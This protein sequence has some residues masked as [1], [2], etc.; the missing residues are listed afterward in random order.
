MF[1]NISVPILSTSWQSSDPEG[2]NGESVNS[3]V[4]KIKTNSKDVKDEINGSEVV[5][6]CNPLCGN[7]DEGIDN[8]KEASHKVN[9]IQLNDKNTKIYKHLKKYP[10]VNSW[11]KIFHWTPLP[12]I[13]HPALIRVLFSNTLNPYTTAIDSYLDAHLTSLDEFFPIVNTLRMRD[14]RNVILDDP[15]KNA[16]SK[17]SNT[18]LNVIDLTEKMI[19]EPTRTCVQQVR[20]LRNEYIPF[21]GNQPIIRSQIHRIFRKLNYI[22]FKNI[23]MSFLYYN[24]NKTHIENSVGT[25]I[26]INYITLA[27]NSG[28]TSQNQPLSDLD[29]LKLKPFLKRIYEELRI[30]PSRFTKYIG[31]VYQESKEHRGDG[32]TIILIAS[33]ETIRK[34]TSNGAELISEKIAFK[35][36]GAEPLVDGKLSIE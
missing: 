2:I 24:K 1:K 29:V 33:L 22:M 11:I 36:I 13:I 20:N 28:E 26:S 23:N 18:L 35:L 16:I 21:M 14:I 10:I 8:D 12:E 15:I 19:I 25:Q 9:L 6:S 17:S 4:D 34:L 32:R 30:N 5:S 27:D 3:P 7:N 31:S